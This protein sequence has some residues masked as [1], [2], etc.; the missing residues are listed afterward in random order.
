MQ[1]L[2][3][4]FA[5]QAAGTMYN[6]QDEEDHFKLLELSGKEKLFWTKLLTLQVKRSRAPKD[7]GGKHSTLRGN[8]SFFFLFWQSVTCF[9]SKLTAFSIRTTV[10]KVN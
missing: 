9:R 7:K 5:S 4:V 6:C 8:L 2:F 10:N 3:C 1:T